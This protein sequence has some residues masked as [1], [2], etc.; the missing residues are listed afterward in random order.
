M[1]VV[2]PF[3]ALRAV[4]TVGL[5]VFL[6]A[7][8]RTAAAY[9][10]QLTLGVDTGYAL[11]AMNGPSHGVA[12]GLNSSVGLGDMFSL[13]GRLGYAHH[14]HGEGMHVAAAGAEVIYLIDVLEWV[15]YFGLGVDGFAFIQG[16]DHRFDLG[17][18][19]VV[20]IEWLASRDWLIGLD[21]RPFV[22]PLAFGDAPLD[23]VYF[24]ATLRFSFIF[25]LF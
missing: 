24:T 1:R 20:G 17:F 18:H 25:D 16:G 12:V 13:R 15:P 3:P 14:P 23:P 19:A 6:L 22:L 5:V 21:L 2:R 11:A 8:P 9:E 7:V 10:D 4:G